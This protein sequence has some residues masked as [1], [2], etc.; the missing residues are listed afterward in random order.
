[1]E[2][3]KG[4][5]NAAAFSPDGRFLA[6]AS[7]DKTIRI[8]DVPSG[9]QVGCLRGHEREVTSVAFSPDGG[10]VVSG[11]TDRTVRVWDAAG[12]AQLSCFRVED[13]GT[14]RSGWSGDAGKWEIHAVC[15]VAF[16]RDGRHVLTWSDHDCIRVWDPATGQ[17]LETHEGRTDFRAFAAG[18]AWRA[19]VRGSEVQ[20]EAAAGG[21]P[22]AWLP[23]PLN[24]RTPAPTH[25]PS[26]GTWTIAARGHLYLFRLQ[27]SHLR[28]SEP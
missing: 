20:I 14:W 27:G 12:A 8:W 11:A 28:K 19:F 13:P 23:Y 5:V 18:A 26:G 24:F 16:S 7:K 22:V 4:D 3:H 15:G 6:S 25:S 2:G 10:R 9:A 21:G 17:C 1:L